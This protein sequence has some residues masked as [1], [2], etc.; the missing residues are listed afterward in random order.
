MMSLRDR[1]VAF[2]SALQRDAMLRQGSP[3]DDIMAFVIAET[4][5]SADDT[6]TDTLPLVLY[7]G[8]A[9]ER[10]EFV[11]VMRDAKPNMITKR[12]P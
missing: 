11:A 7:F 12:L 3:V 5:R 9:V 6:L 10:D 4:G 8:N 2:Y 1:C